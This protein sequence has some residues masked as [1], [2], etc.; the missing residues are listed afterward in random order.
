MFNLYN[1]IFICIAYSLSRA[2]E[3]SSNCFRLHTTLKMR[4]NIIIINLCFRRVA[5]TLAEY[6]ASLGFGSVRSV[7]VMAQPDR[8]MLLT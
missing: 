3:Y 8:K 7:S 6:T 2:I 5:N 1:S 4:S